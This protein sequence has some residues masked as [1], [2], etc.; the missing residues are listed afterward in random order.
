MWLDSG[1]ERNAIRS[2]MA[3]PFE[4]LAAVD[5]FW[6]CNER[7]TR[8]LFAWLLGLLGMDHAQTLAGKAVEAFG[9]ADQ[10]SRVS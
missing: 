4:D 7:S 5:C 10:L 1:N 9:H 6:S 2:Y 3:G 8:P